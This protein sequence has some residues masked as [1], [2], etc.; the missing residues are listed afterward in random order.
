VDGSSY[1]DC[2]CRVAYAERVVGAATERTVIAAQVE[3]MIETWPATACRES[4]RYALR[5]VL[6]FIERREAKHA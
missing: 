6:R 5:E 4:Q 1:E 3:R 2:A